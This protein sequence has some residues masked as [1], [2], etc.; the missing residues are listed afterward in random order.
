[1]SSCL[2]LHQF[3]FS[4]S[5]RNHHFPT[6]Y[7]AIPSNSFS[8]NFSSYSASQLLCEWLISVRIGKVK[9]T[10]SFV[11]FVRCKYRK[12]KKYLFSFLFYLPNVLY[13]SKHSTRFPWQLRGKESSCQF[14]RCGLDPWIGK[15]PWKR[16]WQTIP[17]FL[18]GKF[19]G[20][21]SLVGYNS[22]GRKRVRH[23]LATKQQQ[24]SVNIVGPFRPILQLASNHHHQH[25][26]Y[27]C[28]MCVMFIKPMTN[29][30]MCSSHK[31][32]SKLNIF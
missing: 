6:L 8:V 26:L 18:P 7:K 12:G 20:Q 13:T 25:L 24:H 5:L 4:I 14:R 22:W 32:T 29:M 23:N 28:Y 9:E 10:L 1:M 21:R 16:K 27:T 3:I 17:L 30:T 31:R 19:H 15:I 11:F 2:P